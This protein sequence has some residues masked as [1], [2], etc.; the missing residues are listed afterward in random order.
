M[1]VGRVGAWGV[2]AARQA[3][4][5]D[6]VE[7]RDAAIRALEK[8]GTLDCLDVLRQHRDAEAWLHDY[9]QQVVQDLETAA[10]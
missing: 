2:Q 9:V 8:W 7:V 4:N 5:H 1:G 10:T 3:I 6:D